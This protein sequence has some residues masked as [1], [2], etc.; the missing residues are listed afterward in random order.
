MKRLIFI[1]CTLFF[2]HQ[3]FSQG[4]QYLKF[5]SIQHDFGVVKEESEKMTH[6]FAFKN[7]SIDT[8]VI[9]DV[10]TSCGCTAGEWKKTPL[11]PGEEGKILVTYTTAH[12]PGRFAQYV[13]VHLN[14][15]STK[16]KLRIFG[17]VLP[18]EKTYVDFYPIPMG[19]LRFKTAH[20]TFDTILN[21]EVKYD[22]LFMFN[23][24][25]QPMTVAL[26]DAPAFI[27]Y[28][29][30]PK[31]F[32]PHEEGILI[33][34]Y[35]AAKKNDLGLLFDKLYIL[36]NDSIQSVKSFHIS[37]EILENFSKMSL[38]DL[39][40]APNIV[41]KNVTFDFDTIKEG[42]VIKRDFKFTNTGLSDLIIRKVAT[43]CGCTAYHVSS[44]IIKSGKSGKLKI[45]FDSKNKKGYQR[46]TITVITN[47]P[48]NSS[49]RLVL[50]G[51]V[52]PE[53]EKK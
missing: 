27:T 9:N 39:K 41:F 17:E 21:N 38:N 36:T 6:V 15:D 33:L 42:E 11:M 49:I 34:K 40:N 50:Q 10:S 1:F 7:I 44:S 48:H 22:T 20:V 31:I 45:E 19:N 5:E 14:K 26:K 28:Q 32:K 24:W 30:V 18:R 2:V 13:V 16:I 46:Q 23:E 43:S 35:D 29:A 37:A 8:V 47:N 53:N 3:A 51:F 12:R 4:Q 25:S 52:K